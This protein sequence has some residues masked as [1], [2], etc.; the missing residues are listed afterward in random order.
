MALIEL[1]NDGFFIQTPTEGEVAV[2]EAV[3]RAFQV[4]CKHEGGQW[5]WS[6]SVQDV[7]ILQTAGFSWT[8]EAITAALSLL[9]AEIR[10][11]STYAGELR[12]SR[13]A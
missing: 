10:Q 4:P 2:V 3:Y 12:F 7:I 11:A 6:G 1:G 5:T 9:T 13:S 8:M